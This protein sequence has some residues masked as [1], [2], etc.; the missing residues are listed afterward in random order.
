MGAAA[1]EAGLSAGVPMNDGRRL[2]ARLASDAVCVPVDVQSFGAYDQ[3][4][5]L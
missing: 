1:G 5:L 2:R 4:T 3:A